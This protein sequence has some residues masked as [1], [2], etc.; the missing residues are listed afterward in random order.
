[1]ITHRA[2]YQV[3]GLA[4]TQALSQCLA[5]LAIMRVAKQGLFHNYQPRSVPRSGA[6]QHLSWIP[7]LNFASCVAPG[8]LDLPAKW[9][10]TCATA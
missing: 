8:R 5:V 7:P 1:M 2:Q 4:T 6:A 9:R 3:R 10:L